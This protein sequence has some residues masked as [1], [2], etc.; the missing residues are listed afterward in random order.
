MEE[1]AKATAN[2]DEIKI[3]DS[4]DDEEEESG[5]SVVEE[6]RIERQ[7][8]PSAVFGNIPEDK[9]KDQNL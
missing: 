4:D 7:V 5:A 9:L 1:L 2:P 8:V 6:V 3:G